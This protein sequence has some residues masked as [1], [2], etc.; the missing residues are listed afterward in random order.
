MKSLKFVVILLLSS[1]AFSAHAT[2]SEAIRACALLKTSYYSQNQKEDIQF[3]CNLPLKTRNILPSVYWLRSREYQKNF[4][5]KQPTTPQA[6]RSL[7]Q[8][9]RGDVYVSQI[10]NSPQ[11]CQFY[12]SI[13]PSVQSD[14]VAQGPRLMIVQ[15]AEDLLK[16]CE[17]LNSLI[18][19]GKVSRCSVIE[20]AGHSTES[21]GLDT[22]I[23]I[24]YALGEKRI[25]PEPWLMGEIS[26]CFKKVLVENGGIVA[27][28]CGGEKA[29]DGKYHYW[30]SKS[31]AQQELSNLLELPIISGIGPVRFASQY[32]P[33]GVE[34]VS[35]WTLTNPVK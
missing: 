3:Y 7:N 12:S 22:I 2:E 19:E 10:L 32:G 14:R 25:H 23:G 16:K 8:G 5:L 29:D 21:V 28:T 17:N 34:A 18:T 30:K 35:G 33:N 31:A 15:D 6:A 13:S 26:R 1:L 24:D 4:L 20:L 11:A 9:K 27:S